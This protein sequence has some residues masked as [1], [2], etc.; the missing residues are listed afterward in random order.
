MLGNI[1]QTDDRRDALFFTE[2]G[3]HYYNLQRLPRRPPLRLVL[4]EGMGVTSSILPIFIPDRAKAL[5]ADCAPGPGV[6]VLQKHGKEFTQNSF[7]ESLQKTNLIFFTEKSELKLNWVFFC[8]QYCNASLEY[9]CAR[10]LEDIQIEIHSL[11]LQYL[12]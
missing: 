6:F 4:S 3:I 11:T 9:S 2:N 8:R 10:I 5:S 12:L 7:L 1:K